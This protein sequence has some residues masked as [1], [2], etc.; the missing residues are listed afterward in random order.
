VSRRRWGCAPGRD[1]A[2]RFLEKFGTVALLFDLNQVFRGP[3]GVEG[4]A[5]AN[6][7]QDR[8]QLLDPVDDFLHYGKG[9]AL[10]KS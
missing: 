4:I 9:I 3:P 7:V 1:V 2:D 8:G 10:E 5:S 6:A